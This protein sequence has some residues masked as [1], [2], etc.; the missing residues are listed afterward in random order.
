[1]YFNG[2]TRQVFELS[3]FKNGVVVFWLH[4]VF[5]YRSVDMFSGVHMERRVCW[6]VELLKGM[7]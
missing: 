4:M 7:K 2:A 1:M 5:L 6:N 3:Y